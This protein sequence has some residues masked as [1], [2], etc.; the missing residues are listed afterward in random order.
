MRS[1]DVLRE[2]KVIGDDVSVHLKAVESEKENQKI[3]DEFLKFVIRHQIG[4]RAN[5]TEQLH[6]FL[7]N[8]KGNSK[9]FF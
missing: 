5:G 1:D 8:D 3:V 4:G 2:S 7:E 9:R 6:K